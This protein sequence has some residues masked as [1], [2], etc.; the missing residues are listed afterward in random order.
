ML[1]ENSLRAK[2]ME[3]SGKTNRYVTVCVY[4]SGKLRWPSE[5][6]MQV[7]LS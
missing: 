4:N 1:E 7:N 2:N 3:N 6:L 5:A